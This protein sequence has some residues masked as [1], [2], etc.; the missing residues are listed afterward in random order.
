MKLEQKIVGA[1]VL[2]VLALGA[3]RAWP[4]S[5][6][7][8]EVGS[9]KEKKVLVAYFSHTGNTRAIADMI[10][11]SVGG[12]V[13]EI[14]ATDPYP[15]DYGEVTE[16]AKRELGSNARP[17]LKTRLADAS[18]YDVVFVGYPNWWGTMPMPVMTFLSEN[19]FAGKTVVPFCTHEGSG[20]GRS[21]DDLAKI[22]PKARILD[23]LAI[24]GRRAKDAQDEVADWLRKLGF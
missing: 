2:L 22:C 24:R 5:Q 10:H 8:I 16:R 13:F 23:G 15:E 11:R 20:L 4:G 9:M 14:V 21:G 1:L 18:S 12:D 3:A 19:G 7:A 6:V 17:K